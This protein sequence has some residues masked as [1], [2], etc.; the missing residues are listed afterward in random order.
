MLNQQFDWSDAQAKIFKTK[1][2]LPQ[3]KTAQRILFGVNLF[4][5]EIHPFGNTVQ[6]IA[7]ELHQQHL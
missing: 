2:R 1:I 5:F 6:Q 3:H 4:N 7:V